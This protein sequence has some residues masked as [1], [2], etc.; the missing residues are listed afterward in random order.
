VLI[1]TTFVDSHRLAQ[2]LGY[3]VV[4]TVSLAIDERATK[5]R[6][7]KTVLFGCVFLGMFLVYGTLMVVE[8]NVG[9]PAL[10]PGTLRQNTADNQPPGLG[11]LPLHDS[12]C[13]LDTSEACLS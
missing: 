6:T 2:V 10:L 7:L 13:L 8:R 11:V 5:S 4:G 1:Q 12:A 9:L 3:P